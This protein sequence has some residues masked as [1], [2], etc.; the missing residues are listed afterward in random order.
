MMFFATNYQYEIINLRLSP[1]QRKD[2]WKCML[3]GRFLASEELKRKVQT[4]LRS[5]HLPKDI[6]LK[7][8][9]SHAPRKLELTFPAVDINYRRLRFINQKT[10]PEIPVWAAVVIGSAMPMIFPT[11]IMQP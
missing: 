4:I 6:S 10:L 8:Y 3:L 9:Y 7:D 1:D 2:A 11:F 5:M